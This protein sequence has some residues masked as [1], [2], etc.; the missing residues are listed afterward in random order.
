METGVLQTHNSDI[1][2]F[3]SACQ[4][5]PQFGF[6]SRHSTLHALTSMIE[7]IKK[8][9]DDGMYGCD[10]FIDLQKAFDTVNHSILL[11]SWNIMKL[12]VLL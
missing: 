7:S 3:A 10:V 12:E 5:T 8:T 6:R 1:G 9:I 11:K 2:N 4:K